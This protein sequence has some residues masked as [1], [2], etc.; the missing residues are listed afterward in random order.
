MF[1]KILYYVISTIRR[2]LQ[3]ILSDELD[4]NMCIYVESRHFQLAKTN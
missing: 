3:T 2:K 4:N 1:K